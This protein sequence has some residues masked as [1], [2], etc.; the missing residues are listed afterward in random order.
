VLSLL[1]ELGGVCAYSCA[2]LRCPVLPHRDMRVVAPDG[3]G[4][5]LLLL[6]ELG[7]GL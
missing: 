7:V 4:C 1:T 3:A 6:T 5:W 2:C